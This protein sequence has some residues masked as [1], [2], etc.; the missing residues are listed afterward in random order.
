M[1]TGVVPVGSRFPLFPEEKEDQKRV[2]RVVAGEE[3]AA[4]NGVRLSEEFCLT[5]FDGI[6]KKQK[7][8]ERTVFGWRK[9]VCV[10]V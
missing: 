8:L 2:T 9:S 7:V 4:D 10:S 1:L 5:E 3:E 6:E